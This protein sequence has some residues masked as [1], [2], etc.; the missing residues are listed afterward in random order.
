MPVIDWSSQI[1]FLYNWGAFF[2]LKH[3]ERRIVHYYVVLR[4]SAYKHLAEY[5]PH[6]VLSDRTEGY[7]ESMDTS[8]YFSF[9]VSEGIF[10][11]LL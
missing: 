4:N 5:S 10:G 2:H 9:G 6:M 7:L 11:S 3:M 1:H 8:L